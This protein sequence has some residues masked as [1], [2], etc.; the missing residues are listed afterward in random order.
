MEPEKERSY[1]DVLKACIIKR[2][3]IYYATI[4][5]K[6]TKFKIFPPV[7]LLRRQTPL[8]FRVHVSLVTDTSPS[9]N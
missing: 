4:H 1:E 8:S 5:L 3:Y 6:I 7:V 9:I 2:A